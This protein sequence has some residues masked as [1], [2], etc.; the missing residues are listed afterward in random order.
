MTLVDPHIWT[1]EER[2][3]DVLAALNQLGIEVSREN[4]ENA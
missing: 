2:D 1:L 3:M 4:E